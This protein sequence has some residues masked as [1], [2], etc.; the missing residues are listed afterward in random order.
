MSDLNIRFRIDHAKLVHH[1]PTR[2]C[3]GLSQVVFFEIAQAMNSFYTQLDVFLH[4]GYGHNWYSTDV[5]TV[6]EVSDG[7]ESSGNSNNTGFYYMLSDGH[8]VPSVE[9]IINWGLTED[10]D[11]PA[12][13]V[14]T[15]LDAPPSA[16]TTTVDIFLA[17]ALSRSTNR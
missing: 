2:F 4:T 7:N 15:S 5:E 12:I 3:A 11:A 16:A 14:P 10:L 6:A 9:A 17:P 1:S 8:D 13:A